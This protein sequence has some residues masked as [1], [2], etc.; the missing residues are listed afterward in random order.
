MLGDWSQ[1]QT[2]YPEQGCV[3]AGVFLHTLMNS[4][5]LP[6]LEIRVFLFLRVFTTPHS[7]QSTLQSLLKGWSC[8][9]D[10]FITILG[11]ISSLSWNTHI[12]RIHSSLRDTLQ[13]TWKQY[14]I[15]VKQENWASRFSVEHGYKIGGVLFLGVDWFEP[16]SIVYPWSQPSVPWSNP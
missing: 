3:S 13:Q 7:N 12:H 15:W 5:Y 11:V 1:T 10:V 14:N 9:S 6:E 8:Y 4:I 2:M 16:P